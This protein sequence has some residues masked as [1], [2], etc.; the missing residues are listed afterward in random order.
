MGVL[1]VQSGAVIVGGAFL[2]PIEAGILCIAGGTSTNLNQGATVV[3]YVTGASNLLITKPSKP[4]MER[5]E[6]L[7]L[8][9]GQGNENT[10]II[11]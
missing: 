8:K 6:S 9:E 5:Y 7:L 4:K 2:L 10:T 1:L 3:G 11:E